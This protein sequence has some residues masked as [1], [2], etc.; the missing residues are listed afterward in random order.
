[1]GRKFNR[2]SCLRKRLIAGIAMGSLCFCSQALAAAV[3]SEQLEEYSLDDIVVTA[4]REHDK[5]METPAAQEVVTS[6]DIEANHYNDVAEAMSHVSGVVAGT[7]GNSDIVT[8]NGDER[9]LILVDG[10]RVNVDQGAVLGKSSVSLQMLPSLKNVDRIEVVRGSGSALYGAD[11]VGG[12]I[13]IVTKTA[14]EICTTLDVNTGSWGTYNYELATEGSDGT[15]SWFVDAGLE[16]QNHV[17][18][19]MNGASHKAPHSDSNNNRFAINLKNRF[20]KSSSLVLNYNHRTVHRNMYYNA[21]NGLP[22]TLDGLWSENYN[23]VSLQYNFKEN[24]AVPGYVRFFSNSRIS[25]NSAENIWNC[26]NFRTRTIG[27][28]YQNAWKLGANTL[29]AGAE[30]HKSKSLSAPPA[31]GGYDCKTLKTLSVFLQDTWQID[32]KWSLLPGIRFEHHNVFGSQ[33]VPKV[34]VNYNANDKT[35]VFAS[36]G[37]V[38]RAPTADDLYS[39]L[40]GMGVGNPNLK[41]ETG[42]TETIGFTHKFSKNSTVKLTLFKSVLNDAIEWVSMPSPIYSMPINVSE[43]KRRGLDLSYTHKLSKM[44]SFDVGYSYLSQK[45]G[46]SSTT[47]AAGLNKQPNAYRFGIK[48]QQGPWKSNIYVKNISGL[49][50]RYFLNRHYTLIDFNISY[51][52][53]KQG[54]VYFKVYNLT[55]QEYSTYMTTGDGMGN[56]LAHP[57]HGRFFQIGVTYNF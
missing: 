28:D 30:W 38:F 2:E 46:S 48:Y 57:G 21:I 37:K 31:G 47:G 7:T 3:S 12:V 15:L 8:I 11:A 50:D 55:D 14:K 56:Y 17:N 18:Y 6:E 22:G 9:V 23:N 4:E 44:W 10:Q 25:R 13:N 34:A 24:Q 16:K 43:E 35:Q 40:A 20:D 19:K 41:A 51:D 26:S 32:K 27:A 49:D 5:Q 39:D 45:A 33:W 52:F 53:N 42:H 29:I 36:W 1:M 54:T